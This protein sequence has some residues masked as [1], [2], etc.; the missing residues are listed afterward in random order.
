VARDR[1]DRMIDAL[2]RMEENHGVELEAN[3]TYERWRQTAR[4]IQG[5][6]MKG[7]NKP[8]VA[9]DLPEGRINLSDP[10]SRVMRTQGTAPRQ[11]YNAQAAVNDRQVI[12][13]AEVSIARL[14]SGSWARCSTRRSA[15]SPSG[16]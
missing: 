8:Y 11:A 15:S 13:S 12:L 2:D 6:V 16:A 7:Y 1:D 5:R 10:D 4:D 9:P 3:E 14:T